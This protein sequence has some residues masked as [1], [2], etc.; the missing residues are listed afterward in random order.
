MSITAPNSLASPL[1]RATMPSK[2]SPIKTT[3]VRSAA[4]RAHAGSP[5]APSCGRLRKTKPTVM[6][7]SST[8][9]AV[10]RL[11]IG[12]LSSPLFGAPHRLQ[13]YPLVRIAPDVV[14]ET[15]EY[16]GKE[17]FH[18]LFAGSGTV[19]LDRFLEDEAVAVAGE[20]VADAGH[21]YSLCAQRHLGHAG[22]HG[23]FVAEKAYFDA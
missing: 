6:K 13:Q 20:A 15:G 21:D 7:R 19:G 17:R 22:R 9:A 2:A 10:I 11:A 1:A 12:R 8:R 18:V 23:R 4:T 14:L 5:G 16:A 3:K